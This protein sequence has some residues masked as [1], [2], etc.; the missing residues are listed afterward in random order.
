M[1]GPDATCRKC[2]VMLREHDI[3]YHCPPA[4]ADRRA[5]SAREGLREAY[6]R[7]TLQSTTVGVVKF[8][9]FRAGWDAA[10]L[11][12]AQPPQRCSDHCGR[13]VTQ[14]AD[15][16]V[17][18]YQGENYDCPRCCTGDGVEPR[19]DRPSPA[20]SAQLQEPNTLIEGRSNE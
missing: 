9:T 5:P 11:A 8:D 17:A 2:G 19:P 14:C 20:P 18:D 16:A 4:S 15:C 7:Y 1:P 3:R 6:E 10:L 12:G 13:E